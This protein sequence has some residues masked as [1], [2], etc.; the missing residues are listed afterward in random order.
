MELFP[1]PYVHIGG[2]EAPKTRWKASP[3]AQEVMRREGLK[4]E[5]ELQSYFIRRV[6]KFIN[7]KVTVRDVRDFYGAL[8]DHLANGKGYFITT[9]I[10][11][12][13]ASK[14]AED[15]PI[16]LI[17]EYGLVRYIKKA[18]KAGEFFRPTE[19]PA[20]PK[21]CP[22]CDSKLVEKNWK[23]G[24]FIGC[25]NYPKCRFTEKL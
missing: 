12:L 20:S 10:F 16:E 1:A 24:P 11:T 21:L 3:V 5:E 23:Y 17:D 13:E 14:F 4:N 7:S 2:D 22:H 25:S 15:K 9:N 8:V 18:G 6:E 19:S